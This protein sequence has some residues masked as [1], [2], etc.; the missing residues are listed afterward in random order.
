MDFLRSGLTKYAIIPIIWI[1]KQRQSGDP[2]DP[3]LRGEMDPRLTAY[4]SHRFSPTRE[5]EWGRGE[6]KQKDFNV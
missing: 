2:D 6:R 3:L 4:L 1:L 5:K